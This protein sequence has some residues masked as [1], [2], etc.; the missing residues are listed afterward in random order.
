VRNKLE[1]ASANAVM[2]PIRSRHVFF[3]AILPTRRSRQGL[4]QDDT[5]EATFLL[6]VSSSRDMAFV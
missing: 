3:S 2:H 4:G 5:G 6:V 1:A